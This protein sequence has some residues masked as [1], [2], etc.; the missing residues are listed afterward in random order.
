MKIV[1]PVKERP[2]FF[3]GWETEAATYSVSCSR[4]GKPIPTVFKEMLDG[5]WG[6]KERLPPGERQDVADTFGINLSNR[7]IGNGM[8]AIVK[9]KC[10]SC[11]TTHYIYFWFHEYRHSCYDISLRG[12]AQMETEPEPGAYAD[13]PRRSG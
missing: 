11:G 2:S 12:L 1:E 9:K 5:A 3:N 4:C 8:S 6:W 7:S 10:E 13:K